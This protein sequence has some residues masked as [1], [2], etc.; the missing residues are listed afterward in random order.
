MSL[1]LALKILIRKSGFFMSCLAIWNHILIMGNRYKFD[2]GQAKGS[3]EVELLTIGW[4]TDWC[5]IE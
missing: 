1:K 2:V 5:K 3:E 4:T